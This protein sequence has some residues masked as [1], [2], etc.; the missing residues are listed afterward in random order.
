MQH[1]EAVAESVDP[2]RPLSGRGR[3]ELRLIA[4]FMRQARVKIDEVWH[5]EKLRARQT[6]E[7]ISKEL[8]LNNVLEKKWLKPD[9][10]VKEVFKEI[11]KNHRTVMIVGHMPFLQKLVSSLLAVGQEKKLVKFEPG[12]VVFMEDGQ[13]GWQVAWMVIPEII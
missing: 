9:D 2:S 11:G 10:P 6:A 5:S 13:F 12:G 3:N 4:G 8:A 7:L 1:G